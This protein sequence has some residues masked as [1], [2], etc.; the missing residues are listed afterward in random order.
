MRSSVMASPGD[1]G[2]WQWLQDGDEPKR[3]HDK[4]QEHEEPD[5]PGS[6]EQHAMSGS[7]KPHPPGVRVCCVPM[8]QI[9]NVHICPAH[10]PSIPCT[11]VSVLSP[12]PAISGKLFPLPVWIGTAL[13]KRSSPAQGYE[14]AALQTSNAAILRQ[15][16]AYL[17]PKDNAEYKARI[18]AALALLVASK[19]LNVSVSPQLLLPQTHSSSTQTLQHAPHPPA[20]GPSS[21]VKHVSNAY[22][23]QHFLQIQLRCHSA[24]SINRELLVCISCQSALLYQIGVAWLQVPFLFKYA[25]DA[26]TV[27]P[28]G[29]T[30]ADMPMVQLLPATVLLGYGAARAASSLCNELRNAVFAKAGLRCCRDRAPATHYRPQFSQRPSALL[31]E[32]QGT[33]CKTD[34]SGLSWGYMAGEA[35]QRGACRWLRARCGGWPG[36]SSSICTTWT[37]DFTWRGRPGRSTGS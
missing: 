31:R 8:L 1:L 19:T 14:A 16:G 3:K 37:S 9:L 35:E 15:L 32:A 5:D 10:T 27:D 17:L 12:P 2:H 36:T 33:H 24:M 7:H 4:G 18:G 25:I 26:L 11:H 20:R 34:V 23:F 29:H 28:L 6:R 13:M 22:G 21:A 30:L